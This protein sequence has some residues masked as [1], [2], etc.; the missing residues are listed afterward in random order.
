MLLCFVD[1]VTRFRDVAAGGCDFVLRAAVVL[2]R[3]VDVVTR[4]RDVTAVDFVLRAAVVL[5]RFGFRD[6]T[7][8]DF[9]LRLLVVAAA[10]V[11]LSMNTHIGSEPLPVHIK[12]GLAGAS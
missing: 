4:F 7:A 3:F 6:V 2:L 5:L 1:V 12:G 9:V 10:V 8:V 11:V